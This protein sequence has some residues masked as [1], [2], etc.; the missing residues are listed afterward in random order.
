VT[1]VAAGS[2]TAL[3]SGFLRCA[4]GGSSVDLGVLGFFL[5]YSP[6]FLVGTSVTISVGVI[7]LLAAGRGG[8]ADVR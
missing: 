4:L 3:C 5:L 1:A 6:V 7:W 8:R 2:G